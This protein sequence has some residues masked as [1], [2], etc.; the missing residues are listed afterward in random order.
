MMS[1][2]SRDRILGRLRT[3]EAT[4]E[5]I[6]MAA[7]LPIRSYLPS[8]RIERLK[9]LMT[10]MRTQVHLVDRPAWTEALKGILRDRRLETLL[11][12]PGS[13][14]GQ[15][16]EA[17]WKTDANGLP[18]L[19]AYAA[20]IEDFKEALFGIDAA[21]TTTAGAIAET[22]ALVLWPD[23]VEPRL[24][25][26]VPPVH[27]AVLETDKIYNTFCEI[28]QQQDWRQR[29]P[30]NALLI[31]GPSKTADIEMTLAFGVHGPRELIV[32]I[33]TEA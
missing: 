15:T 24:M 6:E 7:C 12:A 9:Q 26:L 31:S 21:I 23:A 22:G 8:G 29:M 5:T 20:P 33:L 4:S 25:S 18:A 27:I 13:A 3:A 32:L 30:T 1:S 17:A 2:S 28:I 19:R 10:H 14:I 16:L 11:Y